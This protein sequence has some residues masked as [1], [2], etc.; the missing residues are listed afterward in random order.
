MK[1]ARTVSVL[2][3]L[4]SLLIGHAALA[5][6]EGSKGSLRDRIRQRLIER[7]QSQPAPQGDT[8]AKAPITKPGDYTVV[9]DHDGLKRAYKIHVP[10]R[11][12]PA[13]AAPLLVAMHGGGGSM[14]IQSSDAHYGLV[15][16][17]DQEGFVVAFP[18]GY[19]PFPSGK[20]ATWNAGNCCAAARD[21]NADD[22]GFIRKMVGNLQQQLNIDKT[23]VFA[24]GMS[25]G[26]M[27]AQRL[28]C[29]A[30]DIFSAVAPVAG[31][32]NTRSCT[33]QRPVS[34]LM[35]HAK[36]DDHVLFN[37]GA[38][39]PLKPS[40]VTDFT[41]VPETVSRW[42]KRNGCSATPQRVVEKP[43]AYCDRYSACQGGTQVELCVTETGGHSWPGGSKPRGNKAGSTAI[44]ADDV[45][46]NFFMG[47]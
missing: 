10:K 37:G 9:I 23:K 7:Q 25:N 4:G 38:G 39:K 15:S 5:Q 2:A 31:T 29:E 12:D 41:S 32:D 44:L 26:G 24:T 28:A 33:P 20:F 42:V 3:I 36:D 35:F 34:V 14:E 43:G 8:D 17:S 46:W 27:L 19:S 11:Y 30:S 13:I 47:R 6:D 18:N 40:T 1:T 21:R 45:M 22:V 16:K